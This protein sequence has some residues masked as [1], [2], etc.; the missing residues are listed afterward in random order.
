MSVFSPRDFASLW[1]LKFE[2]RWVS[3]TDLS[4]DWRSIG[5]ELMKSNLADYEIINV[6]ENYSV[7]EI[8]KLKE[9]CK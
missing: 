8:I 6:P 9:T 2:H 5:Q 4:D 7:V 1:Y 3:K